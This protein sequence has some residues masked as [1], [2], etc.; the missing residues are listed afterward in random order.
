MYI[1]EVISIW[2]YSDINQKVSLTYRNWQG[3]MYYI[4]TN[5]CNTE[6]LRQALISKCWYPWLFITVFVKTIY[7]IDFQYQMDFITVFKTYH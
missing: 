1:I 3:F 7:L 2:M 6:N 4:D 5:F